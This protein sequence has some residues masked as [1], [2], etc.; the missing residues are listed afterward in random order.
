[1]MVCSLWFRVLFLLSKF[2]STYF[3]A[4][5]I[6]VFQSCYGDSHHDQ[7][8][9]TSLGCLRRSYFSVIAQG[10]RKVAVVEVNS[11]IF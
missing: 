11:D 3:T 7:I 10:F 6:D 5:C 1:M 4:T 8:R 2:A 9:E